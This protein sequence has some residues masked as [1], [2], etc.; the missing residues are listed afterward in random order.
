MLRKVTPQFV[1]VGKELHVKP[2]LGFLPQAA[3]KAFQP[4]LFFSADDNGRFLHGFLQFRG[5]RTGRHGAY[6]SR[7]KARA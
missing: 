2:R 7:K 5:T 4:F 1:R 3:G 6:L